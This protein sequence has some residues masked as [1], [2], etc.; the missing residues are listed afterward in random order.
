MAACSLTPTGGL[1]ALAVVTVAVAR[2][3]VAARTRAVLLGGTLAL[4]LPWLVAGIVHAVRYGGT[5]DPA[6]VA[7]FAARPDT[8]LGLPGSLLTLG[9]VWN[10]DV[11]PPG[12]DTVYAAVAA[13]VGIGVGLA[14]VVR[15]R[16]RAPSLLRDLAVLAA[17]GL[18][19]ALLGALPPTRAALEW[20]TGT[21]PGAG[22]L[23]DGQKWLALAAP[24]VCVAWALG[25]EHLAQRL[26]TRPALAALAALG[27]LLPVL[28]LPGLAWGAHD[29][30]R[31][32]AYP[33]D[34]ERVR[35]ALESPD[36]PGDVVVLPWA[37]FRRFTWNGGR[38]ALDPAP[39]WLP[40]TTVVAD[41]LPVGERTVRGED[42]RAQEVGALLAGDETL[43]P[44]LAAHGVGWV[45][46]EHRTPG[47][48]VPPHALDG[49]V[50]VV[51]GPDL[52]LLRVPDP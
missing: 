22:L 12:R 4:Q 38:T 21:V 6:G 31:P 45:L 5:S 29:R 26:A 11:V 40:R 42:P 41:Y 46:V 30:L 37:A 28:A 8:P 23:R 34:W 44:H 9:G 19:L 24:F 10:A 35:A 48:P 47:P 1:L 50:P 3:D 51:V 52:T 32:V 7:A 25:L 17:L 15:L 33:R 27:L 36:R 39:R 2:R 13:V 43:A 49:L 14:G 18:A 16:R 20:A